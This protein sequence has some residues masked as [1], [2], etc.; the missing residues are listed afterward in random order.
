M[1]SLQP[2]VSIPAHLKASFRRT[3]IL[4]V[5]V[6][7]IGLVALVLTGH[8]LLGLF[9]CLGILLG[10]VNAVLIQR[11]AVVYGSSGTSGDYSAKKALT[12]SIAGRL[13]I[14]TVVAVVI[15]IV[16]A[17]DG[18]AVFGGLMIFQVLMLGSTALP[19]MR[20]M[21]QQ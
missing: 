11:Q 14:T 3:L 18:V 21:R 4:G 19:M 6:G 15:G 1:S 12:M 5:V 13:V 8:A 10:S 20:G 2:V 9:G 16:F 17:P 7:V